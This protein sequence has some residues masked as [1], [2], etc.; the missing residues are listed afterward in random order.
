L[1]GPL[2]PRTNRLMCIGEGFSEPLAPA[3]GPQ[4][5]PEPGPL[6]A[7][8]APVPVPGWGGCRPR[9]SAP[10]PS[11]AASPAPGPTAGG[12]ARGECRQAPAAQRPGGSAE[13]WRRRLDGWCGLGSTPCV[14]CFLRSWVPNP[15]LP[16]PSETRGCLPTCGHLTQRPVPVCWHPW[17]LCR[18]Y[19]PPAS[20]DPDRDG[21]GHCLWGD[22]RVWRTA[23]RSFVCMPSPPSTAIERGCQSCSAAFMPYS[24]PG[25]GQ[26]GQ[27]PSARRDE[28]SLRGRPAAPS[29][30]GRRGWGW[31][32]A[33]RARLLCPTNGTC[34]P[35]PS[36]FCRSLDKGGGVSGPRRRERRGPGGSGGDSPLLEPWRCCGSGQGTSL[37]YPECPGLSLLQPWTPWPGQ[38]S[39]TAFGSTEA[40]A[41]CPH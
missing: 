19:P 18:A 32:P 15:L 9:P 35:P 37:G 24:A 13:V 3:T 34:P 30:S 33:A 20:L 14:S 21:A 1:A 7:A 17:P 25:P 40:S 31:S 2:F 5:W 12:G 16:P 10:L 6:Q 29:A 4:P 22:D 39:A 8:P 41:W 38:R 36:R 23:Q 28:G 27:T 11:P 26:A